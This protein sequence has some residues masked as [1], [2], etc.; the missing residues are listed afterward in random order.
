M[1]IIHTGITLLL[2]LFSTHLL[3][4]STI[5]KFV[6]QGIEYHDNGEYD[7]AIE[8]YK[9]ALDIDQNSPLVHYEIALSFFKKGD[10][11]ETIKHSDIVLNQNADYL[12]Q[13][14]MAKGSALDMLGKTKK[15]I[16]L[17][18]KA[19]KKSGGHYLL[20]Y[21]L[22]LNYYKL[23]E[24]NKAEENVLSAIELNSNHPSSHLI[25]ANIHNSQGNSVQSL[26]ATHYFLFLEPNTSRSIQTYQM[27]QENFG[28][29]VTRDENKP[30]TVN[31]M[32]SINDDSQFGAAELMVSLLEASKSTEENK[33]KTEDELFIENTDS[34]FTIL[35]ELNKKKDNDIWWSFYIPFF[36][37]IADS[38]HIETYCKY[39]SQSGNKNSME[40]LYENETKIEEFD[41]WLTNE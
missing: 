6:K 39:I 30:N 9:K 24:L 17:F 22:A 27:L 20:Y 12:I 26:L 31:I 35:G 28:G 37:D 40:W 5:E 23:N 11:E 34:F 2:L 21:N 13:A 29:N 16:K 8:T 14:Y 3:A 38:E 25:L 19:I 18:E 10:Y 7:L 32:L 36:Y 4:Q 15:S 41:K 1:R 33:G